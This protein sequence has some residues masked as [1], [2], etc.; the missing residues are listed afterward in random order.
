MASSSVSGACC[1]ALELAV[2]AN[3]RAASAGMTALHFIYKLRLRGLTILCLGLSSNDRH[4][5][6]SVDSLE[7]LGLRTRPRVRAPHQD[8]F[9]PSRLGLAWSYLVAVI[10]TYE[11]PSGRVSHAQDRADSPCMPS[12]PLEDAY[13][14]RTAGSSIVTGILKSPV[15]GP[16][17]S[18]AS[19]LSAFDSPPRS[20][21]GHTFGS[22]LARSKGAE[23]SRDPSED[24]V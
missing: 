17:P 12:K 7:R 14:S 21:F 9:R 22:V 10:G 20:T 6:E 2:T 5:R 19:C 3:N 4:V 15:G 24:Q 18:L 16:Q 8:G 11:A 13:Q 23:T 1:W